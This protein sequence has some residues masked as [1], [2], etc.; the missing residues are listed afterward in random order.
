MLPPYTSPDGLPAVA[1][2]RATTVMRVLGHLVGGEGDGFGTRQ[3][4]YDESASLVHREP[5]PE[6]GQSEGVLAIA[7]VRGSDQ[8][9][10][11]R[12]SA[13]WPSMHHCKT[14]NLLARSS[15]RTCEF[16]QQMALTIVPSLRENSFPVVRLLRRDHM[17]M[18]AAVAEEADRALRGVN[19]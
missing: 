12:Y 11:G 18:A 5:A 2:V 16:H 15:R 10:T 3:L 14:P 9:R 7:A 17:P 4:T 19:C 6:V 1:E 13:R 8:L